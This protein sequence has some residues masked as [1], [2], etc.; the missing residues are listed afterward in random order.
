MNKRYYLLR[1]RKDYFGIIKTSLEEN[2]FI[3][4]LKEHQLRDEYYNVDNFLDYL[5]EHNVEAE[6]IDTIEIYY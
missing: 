5:E 1:D 6:F 3:E 4:L 2:E